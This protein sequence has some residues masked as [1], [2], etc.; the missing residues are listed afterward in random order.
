MR[1]FSFLLTLCATWVLEKT[2]AFFI[3]IDPNED[4]DARH[5]LTYLCVRN[6]L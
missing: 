5:S 4:L 6:E 2:F 1:F 3:V